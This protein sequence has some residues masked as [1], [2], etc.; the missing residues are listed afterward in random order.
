[1]VR[2]CIAGGSDEDIDMFQENRKNFNL[3]LEN[4]YN[5]SDVYKLK[6]C[7]KHIDF[8][9]KI[10][11]I[12]KNELEGIRQCDFLVAILNEYK[13]RE[14]IMTKI[15][16]CYM[17]SKPVYLIYDGKLEDLHDWVLNFSRGIYKS[18]DSLLKDIK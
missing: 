11:P 6:S 12:I 2:V 5:K 15:V 4:E 13:V 9:K 18:V 3:Y 8:K 17:L 10:T 16:Y 14:D 7:R 1:M